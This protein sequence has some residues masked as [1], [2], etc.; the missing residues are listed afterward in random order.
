MRIV[1][2]DIDDVLNAERFI[3]MQKKGAWRD[4]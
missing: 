4:I 3:N 2:L 1:F